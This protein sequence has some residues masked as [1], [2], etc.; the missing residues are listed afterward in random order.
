ML[1]YF[2]YDY[3]AADGRQVPFRTITEVGRSPWSAHTH[4][5]HI[6]IKGVELQPQ[7]LPPTNL[8]FLVDVSGSMRAANKVGPLRTGLKMLARQL[9]AQDRISIAVYA[10]ASGV[11]L[12][13]TPGNDWARIAAALDGLRAGGSTNGS[14]G[15]NLAYSLARQS[16]IPGGI[17]RV[18]LATDGDFNVGAVNLNALLDLVKRQRQNQISL[19]TLGF[20]TG[21]INEHLMEQLADAGNGNYA[22]IDSAKEAHKVL[23]QQ[24]AGTLAI[25][26]KEL[27]IQVK[28]NRN[29]VAEYR[30]IGYENRVLRRED[31]NNDK[32]DVGEIGAGHTVTALYEV[33]LV[34][35]RGLRNDAL[36]YQSKQPPRTAIGAEMAHLRIRFKQPTGARSQLLE[37]PIASPLT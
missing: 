27:K 33:S 1:N 2:S 37:T 22:Y 5:L 28:F 18:L 32:V 36:R 8:V 17:N 26:A 3:P 29:V 25:I 23:V 7:Q 20:G 9:R 35:S 34:G 14:A 19:T 24:M 30:F 13:P 16:F 21:N 10:G 12:S 11:A 31:F 15:I 6:G 4:L